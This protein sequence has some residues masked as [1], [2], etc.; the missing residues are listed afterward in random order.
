VAQLLLDAD[1]AAGA[2]KLGGLRWLV[3]TG[4]ALPPAFCRA[5]LARYPEVPIVNAYGPTE[6]ADD[7]THHVVRTAPPPD[8]A[9]VPI[10]TPIDGVTL[11]VLDDALR[12]VPVGEV[13]EL[14][15]GGV[16]VGRGYLRDAVRTAAAFVTPDPI[17]GVPGTRLYR[18]GDAGRRLADGTFEC[19]GRRDRQIKIRGVRVELDE[20]EIVL[21]RHRAVR[22]AAVVARPATG[23]GWKLV[24]CIATSAASVG[25]AEELRRHVAE[26]LP[27]AMVPA[28]F[29]TCATLPLGPNGKIDRVALGRPAHVRVAAPLVGLPEGSC[30][31][32]LA[33]A[34]RDVLGVDVRSVDDDFFALGGDSLSS[35]R[36]VAAMRRQ[37]FVVT[38]QQIFEH[39]TIARIAAVAVS[40]G[41]DDAEQGL[42]V[43]DVE[44]TPIQRALLEAEL[45][46]LDHYNVSVLLEVDQPLSPSRLAIAVEHV[47][48]Q[49]D[50]LRVRWSRTE[51][52]WRQ[53]IAG[54]EGAIPCRRVDLADAA[55]HE[56][57]SAIED[58]ADAEQGTLDLATGPVLRVVWFDLGPSRPGRLL[59]IVH[60]LGCDVASMPIVLED[61]AT[62]C[63]QL[64]RGE[65]IALPPKTTSYQAWAERLRAWG[66]SDAR[67]PELAHWVRECR[68]GGARL[69]LGD[70]ERAS[71]IAA[72]A[73]QQVTLDEGATTAV[74]EAALEA[75]TTVEAVLLTA[76]ALAI[77]EVAGGDA[78]LVWLERHGRESSV[79]GCDVSRTV[80]WFTSIFPVRVPIAP[81][82]SPHESLAL[83]DRHLRAIPD[84][85]I[86]YGVLRHRAA[87][88]GAPNDPARI[89]R[90]LARPEISFNYLG[91]LDPPDTAG[92]RVA[93]E[94]SGREVG[95][96]GAR[97]T[98]LDVTAHLLGGCLDL[99]WSYDPARCGEAV[100]ARLADRMLDVV[101]DLTT[102]GTTDSTGA[103]THGR[104][105]R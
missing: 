94:S 24:A 57:S 98:L 49:H 15:V 81:S 104:G 56:V 2:R 97:P 68:D 43:G 45:D 95:L 37:G 88:D 7:V 58:A 59:L 71:S 93:R 20:I 32:L 50:M 12:P 77:T 48:R 14:C 27:E 101:R 19:L 51:M 46:G 18:T 66:R 42:V 29:E 3:V 96:R 47:M 38:P 28:A 6:C 35:I 100:V 62:V 54:V 39:R 31:R 26:H 79:P 41:A 74:L 83:A 76:L 92:W 4:E 44:P 30:E 13:G 16:A 55:D 8:A 82:R 70:T 40:G 102:R 65:A 64:A 5:W 36:V 21:Q 80:G 33:A 25:L 89:L 22:Q 99:A 86:G 17:S 73:R 69:P 52:G 91:R 1:V 75:S 87:A 63:R 90:T 23:G 34:W 61:L 11:H 53:T 85:G 60:H 9:R 10:G 103:A 72:T 67:S 78:V 84:G 105:M